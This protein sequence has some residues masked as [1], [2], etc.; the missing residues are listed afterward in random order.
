MKSTLKLACAALLALF[1]SS[2]LEHTATIKLN[3][4]GSGTITEETLFSAEASAMM[5]QMGAAG[6]DE[7]PLSKM[8]D[9]GKA[10]DNA[11]AMGEGVSV[12]KVE[13]IDKD[14][15]KG[16]RVVYKFADINQVKYNF[17]KS[18]SDAGNDMGPPGDTPEADG[19]KSDE[20][21]MTFKYED[22][23]LTMENPDNKAEAADKPADGGDA[24]DAEEPDPQ[25]MAMMQGFFKD[26][27]MSLKMEIAGGIGETTATHVDGN[28]ITL[29]EIE[30]GKLIGDPAN[31]KKLNAMK[32]ESP[33]QVAAAFKDVEGLKIETK[34]KIT[35][36]VK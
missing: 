10:A 15:R 16:G 1:T 7:D 26:M 28:T 18:M 9:P 32:D 22:G 29:A 12:E 27:K 11:K 36:K 24:P 35:V 17:G 8:S 31:M 23:V 21:P 5:A 13:K 20:K 34:D 33:A 25:A 6:G 14:G 4:D 19:G 3:K 30:F 2:C